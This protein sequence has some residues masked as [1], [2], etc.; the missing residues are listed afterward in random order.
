ML[1]AWLRQSRF[2]S[3]VISEEAFIIANTVT[4]RTCPVEELRDHA[5]GTHPAELFQAG[6]HV[7]FGGRAHSS[8]SRRCGDSPAILA[9]S[10][11][12]ERLHARGCYHCGAG[13]CL[14]LCCLNLGARRQGSPHGG[15]QG[16]PTGTRC[17]PGLRGQRSAS[18][19]NRTDADRLY[20]GCLCHPRRQREGGCNDAGHNHGS[21]DNA[22]EI[23]REP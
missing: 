13:F 14:W 12:T 8:G 11:A 2:G 4:E 19:E 20:S 1:S 6:L 10:Y 5:R 9:K 18:E 3:E 17:R 23:A 22:S 15:V 7:H 21:T 16:E